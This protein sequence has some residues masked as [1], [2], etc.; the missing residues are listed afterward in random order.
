MSGLFLYAL[1]LVAA[2]FAVPPQ[3]WDGASPEF[4]LLVGGI[5]LW[6]YGWGALHLC[7][8]LIYR[9]LVFPAMR[10]RVDALGA[11]GMPGHV[12][13]LITSY[14]IPPATSN[15]VY[16]AALQEACEELVGT[17]DSNEALLAQLEADNDSLAARLQEA[18][19][20]L[21]A[22]Q[23]QCRRTQA[24]GEEQRAQHDFTQ[25]MNHAAFA[26]PE[27]PRDDP[28]PGDAVDL[29]PGDPGADGA[30]LF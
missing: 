3:W 30:E 14:R 23:E 24:W 28:G 19:A 1:V 26:E 13:L 17:T 27:D 2:G 8:S 10:E 25:T 5:A 7:R 11:A 6:R 18:G 15:R 4:L 16:R 12:Y 21:A 29:S 20:Q 9:H 22:S